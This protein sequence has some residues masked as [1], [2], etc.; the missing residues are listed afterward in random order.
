MQRAC[1][2]LTFLCHLSVLINMYSLGDF[3]TKYMEIC[4]TCPAVGSCSQN[5]SVATE[6]SHRSK[7]LSTASRMPAI[8]S[9]SLGQLEKGYSK[10]IKG[11]FKPCQGDH[12]ASNSHFLGT[13]NAV[14]ALHANQVLVYASAAGCQVGN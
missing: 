1:S 12:L 11:R 13:V 10:P 9:R 7:L 2:V 4:L 8:K 5:S 3:K 6:S 14:Q